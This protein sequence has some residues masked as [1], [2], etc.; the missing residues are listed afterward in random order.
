MYV[1]C[2]PFIKPVGAQ[3]PEQVD[4]PRISQKQPRLSQHTG[5]VMESPTPG[6][7]QGTHV[8]YNPVCKHSPGTLTCWSSSPHGHHQNPALAEVTRDTHFTC[9]TSWAART[10]SAGWRT[11]GTLSEAPG[12]PGWPRGLQCPSPGARPPLERS[13]WHLT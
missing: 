5:T 9:W 1:N 11:P 13:W 12:R 2:S 8:L 4:V 6:L 10:A 3:V 7:R